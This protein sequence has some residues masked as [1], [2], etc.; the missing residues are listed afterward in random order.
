MLTKDYYVVLGISRTETSAGIKSAYRTLARGYHADH[1]GEP[2]TL[3][4]LTE[5]DEAYQVLSDPARRR[6]HDRDLESAA[7]PPPDE[8][9]P[10]PPETED[11]F[12]GS[13]FSLLA[14]PD[15]IWPSGEA[16]Q[17]RLARN[18]TGVGVP[19]G[20]R[21]EG[22]NME[23]VLTAEEAARGLVLR[24]RVPVL[25][26]CETCGGSG[27]D[28]DFPCLGCEGQGTEE[29]EATVA[30]PDPGRR[31]HGDGAGGTA[32]APG[33]PQPGAAVPGLRDRRGRSVPASDRLGRSGRRARALGGVAQPAA[34][35]A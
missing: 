19:K 26:R 17:E 8:P 5:I 15:G 16:L 24:A 1:P 14:E 23:L 29:V 22:L 34:Y 20:E 9:E 33:N 3:T 7:A 32:R 11:P 18:F 30:L 12:T 4:E 2:A 28:R 25:R 27:H 13:T 35:S 6:M 31:A 10:L 21:I